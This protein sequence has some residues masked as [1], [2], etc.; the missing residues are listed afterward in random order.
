MKKYIFGAIIILLFVL[1]ISVLRQNQDTTISAAAV[2]AAIPSSEFKKVSSSTPELRLQSR[3]PDVFNEKTGNLIFEVN[4]YE[5]E[6]FIVDSKTGTTGEIVYTNFFPTADTLIHRVA[7]P[8]IPGEYG[9]R[10]RTE[11]EKKRTGEK[12][13]SK[14][15]EPKFFEVISVGEVPAP[16]VEI[17]EPEEEELLPKPSG[18]IEII[19]IDEEVPVVTRLEQEDFAQLFATSDDGCEAY[20]SSVEQWILVDCETLPIELRPLAQVEVQTVERFVEAPVAVSRESL[21]VRSRETIERT[22][23]N[24]TNAIR[25]FLGR[26]T[27]RT[28]RIET[29]QATFLSLSEEKSDPSSRQSKEQINSQLAVAAQRVLDSSTCQYSAI[30]TDLQ[31]AIDTY[32]RNPDERVTF[33]IVGEPFTMNIS[34]LIEFL[35]HRDIS[36][37]RGTVI[38]DGVSINFG[39]EIKRS[40]DQ[41]LRGS[42]DN[43]TQMIES[44]SLSAIKPL[45]VCDPSTALSASRELLFNDF[46]PQ[47]SQDFIRFRLSASSNC[48]VQ[49][50]GASFDVTPTL[51][52]LSSLDDLRLFDNTGTQLG[53]TISPISSSNLFKNVQL[54][55][56]AGTSKV[57]TVRGTFTTS[58]PEA[59]VLVTQLDNIIAIDADTGNMIN[60][61]TGSVVNGILIKQP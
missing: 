41:L 35:G 18:L 24:V 36:C 48:N 12:I 61:T 20:D 53:P 34:D 52:S 32:N 9:W 6:V 39:Q 31:Q 38:D 49:V 54:L 10:T 33:E 55:L 22:A 25:G 51:F 15:S 42:E 57:L 37:S 19:P 26:V 7:T 45:K 1:G 13:N 8:L 16:I 47:G 29:A 5:V 28:T 21:L 14:Y 3:V 46:F 56:P 2:G 23:Q 17:E 43:D 59:S 30:D 11:F 60:T 50:S 40:D 27:G 44:V 58:V 4:R